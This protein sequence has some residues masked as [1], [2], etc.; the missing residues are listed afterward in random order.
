MPPSIEACAPTTIGQ[1]WR[2]R[3]RRTDGRE[4]RSRIGLVLELQGDAHELRV[5][6]GQQLVHW[7]ETVS[8]SERGIPGEGRAENEGGSFLTRIVLSGPTQHLGIDQA[9]LTRIANRRPPDWLVGKRLNLWQPSGCIDQRVR[10]VGHNDEVRDPT[11]RCEL[12][13][14]APHGPWRTSPGSAPA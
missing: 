9:S 13:G 12:G 6:P 11:A 5:F 2:T 4:Q 14:R 1:L 3:G 8:R 7:R 10:A